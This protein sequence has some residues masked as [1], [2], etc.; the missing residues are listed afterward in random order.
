M[1][2]VDKQGDSAPVDGDQQ[3]SETRQD[4]VTADD[5]DAGVFTYDDVMQSV[6]E[7]GESKEPSSPAR[8]P[9][10]PVVTRRTVQHFMPCIEHESLLY[11]SHSLCVFST[12]LTFIRVF[13]F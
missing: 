6:K 11:I 10:Y 9:T 8:L 4:D 7:N 5:T 2:Y 13:C 3:N 1:A 12:K